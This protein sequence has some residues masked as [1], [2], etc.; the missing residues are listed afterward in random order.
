MKIKSKVWLEKNSKLIFGD[1]KSQILKAIEE[2]GSINKAAKKM[3]ISFRHAWGYITAIE[4][5]AGFKLIERNKG[6][7]GG[8]GSCLTPR[9]K[10][11]VQK[12]DR[13]KRAVNKF[14]DKK[15]KEIFGG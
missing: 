11:L 6:G 8:G 9:A 3:G 10:E 14:T 2:A 1:G 12:F 7:I 4:R 13:L 15:S 5:R